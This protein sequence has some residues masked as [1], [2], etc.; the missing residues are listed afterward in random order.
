MYQH[1]KA[2]APPIRG[3]DIILTEQHT[4]QAQPPALDNLWDSLDPVPATKQLCCVKESEELESRKKGSETGEKPLWGKKI[5][6]VK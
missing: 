6:T 3:H 1:I 4:Q 5:G 2:N